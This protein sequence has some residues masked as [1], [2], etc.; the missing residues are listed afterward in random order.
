[1]ARRRAGEEQVGWG[2]AAEAEN[3]KAGGSA[4]TLPQYGPG[5]AGAEEGETR[6]CPAGAETVRVRQ[7]ERSG[8]E[9]VRV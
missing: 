8:Q 6:S 2:Q 5:R 9:V 4:M 3:A 1:M 7:T